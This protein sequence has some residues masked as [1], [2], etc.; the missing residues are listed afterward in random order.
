MIST[1]NIKNVLNNVDYR[2]IGGSCGLYLQGFAKCYHDIDVI[3]DNVD[4]IKL[5]YKE[6]PLTHKTRINRTKKYLIDGLKF[7]FIENNEPFEV[8][9]IDGLKVQNRQYILNYRKKIGEFIA[10]NYKGEH[11]KY[12]E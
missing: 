5:P 1:D 8:L 12:L 4:Y 10:A 6:L 2:A 7:D 3:V 11:N 9:N